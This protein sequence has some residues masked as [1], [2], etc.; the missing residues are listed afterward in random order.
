MEVLSTTIFIYGVVN[1]EDGDSRA[2][3]PGLDQIVDFVG[4]ENHD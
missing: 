1:A 3:R 4:L 2:G